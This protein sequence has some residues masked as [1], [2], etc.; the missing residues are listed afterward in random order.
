M[1]KFDKI[2]LGTNPFEGVSYISRNQALH[3]LEH[4]SRKENI[5]PVL[6]SAYN[7]GIRTITCTNNETFLSALDDFSTNKRDISLIPLIPNAYEYA[8]EASEKGVL[9]TVLNRIKRIDL[10]QKL[11][12]GM[13]TLSKIKGIISKDVL[14]LLVELIDFELVSFKKLKITGVVLHGQITDLAL[15]SNNKNIIDIYQNLII[16]RYGVQPILA[17]HNFGTLLPKLIE[18]DINIPIMA[19]FNKK[20]FMMRPSKETCENLIQKTDY[21]IIAKKV[22]AGGRISPEEAFSYLTNK[23]I[24]SIVIGLA[25]V[26]EAYHTLGVAKST[27]QCSISSD[28]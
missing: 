14:T 19:P 27:F 5:T 26:S 23:K 17:T 21:Y 8:R 18:W 12:L 2:I 4:F 3:F 24:E 10:Y 7:M 9:G 15:S 1:K 20:G 13:R 16:D 22:L 6:E 28:K 25:S 11:R